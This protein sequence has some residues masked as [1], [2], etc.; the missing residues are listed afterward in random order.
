MMHASHAAMVSRIVRYRQCIPLES[1]G[2]FD[3]RHPSLEE[4][5]DTFGGIAERGIL[6]HPEIHVAGGTWTGLCL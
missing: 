2:T 6:F 1:N 4:F 3:N 5:S